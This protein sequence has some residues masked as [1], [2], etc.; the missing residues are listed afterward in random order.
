MRLY[1]EGIKRVKSSQAVVVHSSNPSTAGAEA[2]TERQRQDLSE[3]E[4]SQRGLQ[5]K[6]QDSQYHIKKPY[7]KN[8]N[9][10]KTP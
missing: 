3:S 8:K 4:S 6:F 7:L 2:D 10:N 5:S 9:T 1:Q